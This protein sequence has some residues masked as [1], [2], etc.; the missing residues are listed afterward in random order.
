M[1]YFITFYFLF[2]R[3]HNFG[4]TCFLNAVLQAL[5]S[6]TDFIDDLTKT[7]NNLPD[8]RLPDCLKWINRMAN[9]RSEKLQSLLNVTL[10]YK[11][12]FI[13]FHQHINYLVI[14]SLYVHQLFKLSPR[15]ALKDKTCENNS[16]LEKQHD[17][18]NF[19]IRLLESMNDSI[20]PIFPD[21]QNPIFSNFMSELVT[22]KTCPE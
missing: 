14:C 22:I 6:R 13:F 18:R 21:C 17:A 1:P 8:T 12:Q 10:E 19:L 16:R 20:R 4:N 15:Y 11:F 3:L 2:Y 9:Q 7:C 5:L